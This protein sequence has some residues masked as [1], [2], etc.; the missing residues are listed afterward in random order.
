MHKLY[1]DFQNYEQTYEFEKDGNLAKIYSYCSMY[2]LFRV[3]VYAPLNQDYDITFDTLKFFSCFS[4]LDNK[5]IKYIEN[6]KG[7]LKVYEQIKPISNRQTQ[8]NYDSK[9]HRF[10]SSCVPLLGYEIYGSKRNPTELKKGE[11]L[12]YK[13][14]YEHY[15]NVITYVMTVLTT[16]KCLFIDTVKYKTVWHIIY[17]NENKTY[18]LMMYKFNDSGCNR[19]TIKS[20]IRN[21]LLIIIVHE[22]FVSYSNGTEYGKIIKSFEEEKKEYESKNLNFKIFYSNKEIISYEDMIDP[23]ESRTYLYSVITYILQK[24]DF[25]IKSLQQ[26]TFDATIKYFYEHEQHNHYLDCHTNYIELFKKHQ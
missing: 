10:D 20:E 1:V 8:C 26:Q 15:N 24:A 17:D 16:K 12:T 25:D 14:L 23:K 3:F 18:V 5:E 22:W 9:S 11:D 7:S 2:T 21:M 4:N 6:I 19:Y 13:H